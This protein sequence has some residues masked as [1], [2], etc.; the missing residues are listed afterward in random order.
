VK[1]NSKRPAGF[2]ERSS[3][4]LGDVGGMIVEYQLDRRTGRIGGIEKLEEFDEFAA[5]MAILDQSVNLTGEQIDAGQQADRAITLIFV[6]AR[7]GRMG[8]GFGRQIRRRHSNRLD[9]G[10]FVLGD[11]RYRIA[12]LLLDRCSGLFDDLHFSVNAQNLRHPLLEFRIAAFQVVAH[13]SGFISSSL[14]I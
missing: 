12:G 1:V 2:G 9:A 3:G 8:S 5:A 6:I 14:R 13:F 7:E 11:D 4:L 10:L